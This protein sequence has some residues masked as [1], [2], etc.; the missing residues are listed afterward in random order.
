[1]TN[2][3]PAHP[4]SRFLSWFPWEKFLIWGLFLSLVYVLRHFFFV[5]FMTFM[6]TYIMTN[7][8]GRAT[9]L[10]SPN[11]E[12]AWLQRVMAVIGFVL[13]LGTIFVVGRLL[14][15][16]LNKQRE[17]LLRYA[18]NLNYEQLLE[19]VLA[20]TIG[21]WRYDAIYRVPGGDLLLKEHLQ[22]F[23]DK[24]SAT[25]AH[26]LFLR[27]AEAFRRKFELDLIE[28]EGELAYRK[29]REDGTDQ[30]ALKQW[31]IHT[32]KLDEYER[33][34]PE[35][36]RI[37]EDTHLDSHLW[38]QKYQS[39]YPG[40]SFE[41]YKKTAAHVENRE[42]ELKLAFVNRQLIGAAQ[43]EWVSI[44]K[45]HLGKE[46]SAD[47]K[48]EN[49]LEARFKKYYEE[50]ATLEPLKRK[51]DYDGFKQREAAVDKEQFE[52]IESGGLTLPQREARVLE[53]FRAKRRQ[54]LALD[55]TSDIEF[56]Q[57]AKL[58]AFVAERVPGFGAW[59]INLGFNIFELLVQTSLSLLLSF[60]ITFD[61]PRLRRGVQQLEHSKARDFYREI[62]PGL[63]NFG[64]LIG[65]AFQ[66]QG[67]IAI[68]NTLL[69]F[70]ALKLIG[71]ENEFFLCAIVLIC[72]FIPVL[73]VVLSSIPIAAVAIL[74]G[75]WVLAVE[76]I[77]AI[78]VI[79]FIETSFLNPKILGDMLHLHPV[80]VLGILAVGEYFFGVWGLLLGVPVSVYLIRTLVVAEPGPAPS[81]TTA[82]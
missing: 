13:L 34:R 22:E 60:F 82:T 44:F 62:A 35:L 66:A 27:E 36:L 5:I 39:Q 55:A 21:A 81:G 23:R 65:R 46:A 76:A 63:L 64:R 79:H 38:L 28:R 4:A 43:A 50:A 14:Y 80:M 10:V 57:P 12:R 74:Q 58:R 19:E 75:D 45:D 72:S 31:M 25:I 68:V 67:V 18:R 3:G 1:M 26:E 16:P 54:E 73:G 6:I 8:V 48:K 20:K 41:E 15:Q 33:T 30:D 59:T 17:E 78:L 2:A 51:Y 11:R 70:V 9:R 49:A 53:N 29:L 47:I 61:M 69:T 37:Y 32:I 52:A 71:I 7:V 40:I 42:Y 56:L 24:E 77:F